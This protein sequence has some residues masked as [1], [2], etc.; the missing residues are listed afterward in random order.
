MKKKQF[1][2]L[3]AKL[4]AINS[5]LEW[6]EKRM[7]PPKMVEFKPYRPLVDELLSNHMN[8][9]GDDQ[10]FPPPPKGVAKE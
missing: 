3:M 1:K 8:F 9:N 10:P 5:G 4:D 7:P 6:I 2:K